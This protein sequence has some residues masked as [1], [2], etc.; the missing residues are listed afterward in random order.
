M[1]EY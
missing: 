1:P